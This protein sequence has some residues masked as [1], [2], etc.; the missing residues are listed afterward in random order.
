MR[1]ERLPLD[2]MLAR[3]DTHLPASLEEVR[4][5]MV[6]DGNC[7]VIKDSGKLTL[8]KSDY[9]LINVLEE[10]SLVLKPGSY[11]AVLSLPYFELLRAANRISV[12]FD[13][14]S[15]DGK[16]GKYSET[17]FM[18]QGLLMCFVGD[19]HKEWLKAMG[20]YCLLLENL[21][22]NYSLIPPKDSRSDGQEEKI[23]Q[24]MQYIWANYGQ[25][26]SMTEIAEKVFL[27]RSV[28]SRLFKQTTGENFPDY[29]K[30]LRL[31]S[32][33]RALEQTDLSIT[34]IALESGFS[35]P[36]VLNRTFRESLG[37]SPTDYRKAYK[38]NLKQNTEEEAD[39]RKVLEILQADLELQRFGNEEIH[40]ETISLENAV[41][42]KPWKNRLLNVGSCTSLLSAR[43][44]QQIAF[45]I[46]RLSIEYI[47]VWNPF[48]QDMMIMGEEKDQYNFTNLDEI[49]D[50]C[51]DHHVK[52]F[53]DLT[54]RRE[55]NMANEKR[56]IS[57]T[58]SRDR[59]KTLDEWLHAVQA[60]VHHLKN[61][62]QEQTVSSW[63]IEMTFSLND[64]PYYSNS[65]YS[66]VSA[67]NQTRKVIKEI[68]P[69]IRLAAPGYIMQQDPEL[70]E[71]QIRSFL[72]MCEHHP[73]V[74]TSLHFP[75][76]LNGKDFYHQSLVKDPNRNFFSQQV[77]RIR[78]ILHNSGF[79]G[80]YFVTEC[81]ISVV[82]RNYIQDSCYRGTTALNMM[83]ENR[84]LADSIGVFYGS[85]L[86]GAFSDSMAT[87]CGSGGLLARNGIRKP[88]YY[89]YRFLH[90]LGNDKLLT[91]EHCAASCF[92]SGDIRIVCLNRKNLGPWY[93]T[94]DEDSFRPE[95]IGQIM[96]NMDS[97]LME[98]KVQGLKKGEKYRIRQ[99]IMNEET[100]SVLHKW[101]KLGAPAILSRDDQEYLY[102]TCIPEVISEERTA[103]DGTIRITFR[104]EAS[105][106]RMIQITKES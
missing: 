62:Y 8:H 98:L 15:L 51:V 67:W 86:I 73:D 25:E 90:H 103:E 97:Y 12:R 4:I 80:E 18:L 76:F 33:K 81:G 2:Y 36:S 84:D 91:S 69:E 88:V 95:E 66:A 16:Q 1:E 50:F 72:A 6:V 47:R 19:I 100:G 31:T 55:R 104:M 9:L 22:S 34:Q 11:V 38:E 27:S 48:S 60:I 63:I 78:D 96:E 65:E 17:F 13:L 56:E 61:R 49:L 68:L 82:N 20:L 93:Y 32:V 23:T 30:K 102:Q 101:R 99:R 77:S 40:S 54:P 10:V 7:Q 83:L 71:E 79:S 35:S 43:M 58:S 26:I 28:A 59:F 21:V 74:F 70:N 37:V 89:A 42:W 106:M 46:E 39:R 87:V 64:I 57:A 85:D 29:L 92:H 24:I 14:C 5:L 52:V 44:Q 41:P 3:Q 105:E 75:Y 45:L 53:L 94:R